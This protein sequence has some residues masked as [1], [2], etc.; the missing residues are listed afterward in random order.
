VSHRERLVVH[1]GKGEKRGSTR[2]TVAI[3]ASSI[4]MVFLPDTGIT[5]SVSIVS[6]RNIIKRQVQI[7][8]I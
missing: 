6:G 1:G 3:A 5:L 4:A 2:D 7:Q 8:Q